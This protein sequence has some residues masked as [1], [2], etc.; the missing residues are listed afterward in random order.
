[1]AMLMPL[2]KALEA[3]TTRKAIVRISSGLEVKVRG[4]LVRV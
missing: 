3:A 1:M 2:K 4:V